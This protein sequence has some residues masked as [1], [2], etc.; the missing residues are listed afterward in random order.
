VWSRSDCEPTVIVYCEPPTEY[1]GLL[2]LCAC[3]CTEKISYPTQHSGPKTV[4]WLGR[5]A[6]FRGI[7]PICPGREGGCMG[8]TSYLAICGCK[9]CIQDGGTQFRFSY[10]H[11]F[12]SACSAATWPAMRAASAAAPCARSSTE[13]CVARVCTCVMQILECVT[14]GMP[15]M[16]G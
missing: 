16:H 4:E 6:Q 9:A 10:L 14:M 13:D 11:T 7:G 15:F 3:T 1:F 8:T 12:R 2:F 5:Y